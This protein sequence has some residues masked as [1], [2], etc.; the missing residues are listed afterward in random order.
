MSIIA[1]FDAIHANIGSLPRGQAAGYTTGTPDIRWTD[2]DF[3]GRPGTVRICQDSGSDHTADVLDDENGAATDADA[4]VWVPKAQ[5]AFRGASR[6]GQRWP[7]IYKSAGGITALV[8]TL[9]AHG[10]KDGV[11]LWVAD[12]GEADQAARAQ[13]RAA[14]GPFPIV[15]VQNHSFN[16]DDES[17]VSGDWLARVSA[18]AGSGTTKHKTV[19]GDT[20]GSLAASRNMDV[21]SWL[22]EQRRLSPPQAEHLVRHAAP[23]VGSTWRSA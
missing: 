17:W 11:Y 6:A 10:I 21:F 19:A 3:A 1:V 5:A 23:E 13:V 7:A 16:S 14:S 22:D 15:G 20:L 18:P 4:A 9:V 2:A 12:W 8:D